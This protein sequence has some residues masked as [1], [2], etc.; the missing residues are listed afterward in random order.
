MSHIIMS[1]NI[2]C[3][4]NLWINHNKNGTNEEEKQLQSFPRRST[5]SHSLTKRGLEIKFTCKKKHV[6]KIN[7]RKIIYNLL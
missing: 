4:D 7:I 1:Q 5:L 3:S 6:L 2:S